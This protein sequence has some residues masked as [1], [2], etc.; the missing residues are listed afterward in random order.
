MK[1]YE[2][3]WYPI[4][5]GMQGALIGLLNKYVGEGGR[6]Q[7]LKE[8]F[9]KTSSK[10]LTS[11]DWFILYRWVGLSNTNGEWLPRKGF[12]T[13]VQLVAGNKLLFQ[14]EKEVYEFD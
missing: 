6:H 2:S 7:V 3:N 11:F 1:E 5:K 4:S 13:E 8:L 12:P 10:E 9:G 14:N